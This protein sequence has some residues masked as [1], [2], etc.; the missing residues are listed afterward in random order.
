M[1]GPAKAVMGELVRPRFNV[2]TIFDHALG[3][4][5]KGEDGL[6]YLNGGWS[7]IMAFGGRGNTFK[8]FLQDF[9]IFT[10]LLRYKAE[11]AGK[12]DTEVSGQ[13]SRLNTVVR[14]VFY[15]NGWDYDEFEHSV[16]KM[17]EEGRYNFTT[18]DMVPGEQWWADYV[19][20]EVEP[21]FKKY[22][23][24]QGLRESPFPEPIKE[25]NRWMLSPWLY[26]IDSLSEFHT[27]AQET[28]RDKS[29][30]GD[31][32]QNALAMTDNKQKADMMSRWPAALARAQFYLGF[33]AQMND[34]VQVGR[35]QKAAKLDDQKGDLDF[36]GVPSRAATFLTNSFLVATK[37]GELSLKGS[38][39]SDTGVS[40]PQ[41]PTARSRGK[42]TS[43]NDLKIIRYTQWRAKTGPTGVKIDMIY[44]Q[45]EGFLAGLSL[46]HYIKELVGKEFGFATSGHF[47]ELSLLPGVKFGRTTVRDLVQ[48]NKRM[49]RALEITAAMAYVQN[50]WFTKLPEAYIMTPQELYD[51]IKALGF[52]WDEILD[53]TV[54][55]WMFKDQEVKGGKRT[56]TLFS[57]LDMAV[58]GLKPKFL[59]IKK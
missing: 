10:I 28:A 2:W 48:E 26:A 33:V 21:R 5:V 6:W 41:Y 1:A 52:D 42:T 13:I 17:V 3:E 57:I 50:N 53:N 25:G 23:K 40:E 54:E 56:L 8:S 34:K 11:W 47:Y 59:T 22:E 46:W 18:A 20:A 9:C 39:N 44:S 43:V 30:I 16:E 36:A 31:G 55:W 12:Y 38:Y 27:S 4:Y 14:S 29:D 24:R 58:N 37:S 45:E 7:H 35:N 51:K 32:D 19:R 49:V 15:A